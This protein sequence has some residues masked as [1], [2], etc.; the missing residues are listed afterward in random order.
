MGDVRPATVN[1]RPGGSGLPGATR[2]PSMPTLVRIGTV[3][4]LDVAIETC[5]TACWN[6]AAVTVPVASGICGSAGYSSTGIVMSEKREEP[7]VRST[8]PPFS[9][10][11]TCWLGRAFE[12]SARRR[13]ETRNVPGASTSALNS[14]REETS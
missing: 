9:S 14:V 6:S 8:L 5:E 2:S 12:I 3:S 13:P 7:Q 11:V 10:S 4:S 1:A